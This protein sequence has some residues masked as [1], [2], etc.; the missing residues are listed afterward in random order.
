MFND[1]LYEI[2]TKVVDCYKEDG[3]IY[4]IL[5]ETVFFPASGGQNADRGTIDNAV[6]MDVFKKEGQIIHQISEVIAGEVKCILDVD[7]RN[8]HSR[9]HSSQHLLSAVIE[10]CG[11]ETTSFMMSENSFSIDVLKKVSRKE[12]DEFEKQINQAIRA[13]INIESRLYNKS[14]DKDVDIKDFVMDENEIRL[15]IIEGIEKNV[16]GGT[17]VKNTLEIE[18]LKIVKFKYSGEK[19]RLT[20]Y[21][22]E[23]AQDIVNEKFNTCLEI[24]KIVNQPNED[25]CV[26]IENKLKESKKMSKKIKKLEKQCQN[27]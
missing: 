15:V 17:H 4:A 6:V 13:G 22:G 21:I 12:L 20:V 9:L 5:D 14:I 25:L 26:V 23:L 3:K 8:L 2:T 1:K 19:T 10:K 27:G 18:F 11:I 7:A 24:E 16:C